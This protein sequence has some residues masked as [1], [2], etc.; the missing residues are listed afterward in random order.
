MY[1]SLSHSL[2]SLA[3]IHSFMLSRVFALW[4]PDPLLRGPCE[5]DRVGSG[6]SLNTKPYDDTF[7]LVSL[8]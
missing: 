5:G 2:I 6:T 1:R 4:G 8:I 7:R 3:P